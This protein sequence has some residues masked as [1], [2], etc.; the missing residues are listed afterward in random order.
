MARSGVP[1][2]GSV[3]E[4]MDLLHAHHE[5]PDASDRDLG[6]QTAALLRRSHPFDKELQ[7]AGLVHGL[8][9]LLSREACPGAPADPAERTAEAVRPLLGDRVARL[10]RPPAPGAAGADPEAETLRQAARAGRAAGLDAGVVED[11][12]PVLELVAAG[13]YQL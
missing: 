12:R 6:L 5:A 3:D 2:F 8:G 4:L 9:R 7:V 10:L 1:A 13:A 11:W